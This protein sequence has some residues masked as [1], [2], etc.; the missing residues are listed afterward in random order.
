M[1]GDLFFL[2]ILP[3]EEEGGGRRWKEE[4][5]GRK[6]KEEEGGGRRRKEER[7][8]RRKEEGGGRR[9][10]EEFLSSIFFSKFFIFPFLTGTFRVTCSPSLKP[11][12]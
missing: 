1:A 4:R 5:G 12:E 11:R 10:K 3:K 8:G 9:R 7:G 2:H 6:R